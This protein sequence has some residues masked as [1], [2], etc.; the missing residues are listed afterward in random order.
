MSSSCPTEQDTQNVPGVVKMVLDDSSSKDTDPTASVSLSETNSF[1]FDPELYKQC[2]ITDE[3]E[4]YYRKEIGLKAKRI[5]S[6]SEG[7]DETTK[8]TDKKVDVIDATTKSLAKDVKKLLVCSTRDG[9]RNLVE[10]HA[11]RGKEIA[12]LKKEIAALKKA[13]TNGLP[14]RD[15]TNHLMEA[16]R[17]RKLSLKVK[18]ADEHVIRNSSKAK[19][20]AKKKGMKNNREIHGPWPYGGGLGESKL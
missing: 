6:L 2:F 5:E 14:L 15:Q 9:Q 19:A 20:A 16:G 11:R 12:M 4:A 10:D 13:Q 18:N 3:D 7:I 17:G 8:S 1:T